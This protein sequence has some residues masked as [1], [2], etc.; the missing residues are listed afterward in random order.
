VNY[1]YR[2]ILAFIAVTWVFRIAALIGEPASKE[3]FTKGSAV[4][5]LVILGL[6]FLAAFMA[7]RES[8]EPR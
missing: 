6:H 5:A 8:K 2:G 7:G 4:T 1:F 3:P